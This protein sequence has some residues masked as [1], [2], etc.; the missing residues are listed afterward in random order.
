MW[1]GPGIHKSGS[2]AAADTGVRPRSTIRL[3]AAGNVSPFKN[4][5]SRTSVIST[6]LT[7]ALAHPSSD[8]RYPAPRDVFWWMAS[9]IVFAG[10]D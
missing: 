9:V 2:T 10:A 5:S 7:P 3:L 8:L 6:D 1:A 4:S